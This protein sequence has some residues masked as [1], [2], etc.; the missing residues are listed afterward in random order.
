MPGPRSKILLVDDE[1]LIQRMTRFILERSNYEVHLAEDGK[2]AIRLARDLRPGLILL[3][4]QMPRMD[5]FDVLQILKLTP[6]TRDIPVVMM[7]SL[8]EV[9]D[10]SRGLQ[11]GAAEYLTKP[12]QAT[13]LVACVARHL[14]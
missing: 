11:L 14:K 3:D 13:D 10:R 5:G 9:T 4:I 12:F 2:E 8:A 6:E 1:K 7:S